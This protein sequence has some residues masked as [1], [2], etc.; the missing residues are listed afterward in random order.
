MPNK[1]IK[2]LEK[3]KKAS[4]ETGLLAHAKRILILKNLARE[5]RRNKKAIFWANQKD[6]RKFSS[7]NKSRGEMRDRLLLNDAR[8]ENMARELEELAE[9][10]DPIGE[11]FDFRERHGLKI[12]KKRIP[13]GVIGII[14]ESRPNVTVDVAGI[15]L[16]SGNTAVLKGGKEARESNLALY[17]TIRH[18]LKKS[19]VSENAVQLIDPKSKEAAQEMI[20]ANGLVD[21]VIPRGGAGLIKFVRENATVPVIE[22]GSG[23]C[24]TY[25]DNEVNLEESVKVVFNAKT[26]RPSVC[27]ALDTLVIHEKIAR[28]FLLKATKPLSAKK[29]EIFADPTSY[30]I[31]K[32]NY[33]AGLLKK[34]KPK[35]FGHEFLSLKMSI[36]TV[37]SFEEALQFIIKYSSGHSEAILTENKKKAEKFMTEINSSVV[38]TNA[39]TRFSDGAMF[40]LGSEIGISTSKLHARGPMGTQ[41]MTTYKWTVIGKYNARE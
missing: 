30:K 10:P 19:G 11:I 3:A 8:I 5:I 20:K 7:E 41:D 28:E 33:P 14:Y 15:C 37:T 16:K 6:L 35:H 1:I 2:Q 40:G 26:S 31:L 13:I 24:H 32:K 22:T 9:M 36:K 18:A 17:K 27:N 23:V 4:H 12:C 38:Y 34:A 39:S 29:V 25:V 21:V